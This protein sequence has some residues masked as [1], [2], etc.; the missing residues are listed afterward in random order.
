MNTPRRLVT[1]FTQWS[2]KGKS[3]VARWPDLIHVL[4]VQVG[5]DSET[6]LLHMCSVITYTHNAQL[7]AIPP[8]CWIPLILVPHLLRWETGQTKKEKNIY[9]SFHI[10]FPPLDL[11]TPI[12]IQQIIQ[13][14]AI[15][16]GSGL[17]GGHGEEGGMVRLIV[18]S[19][20]AL[21]VAQQWPI[22]SHWAKWQEFI[23]I[24]NSNKFV[25]FRCC[26]EP[27]TEPY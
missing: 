15:R 24:N 8:Y 10:T 14:C 6:N 5:V 2:F 22:I 20:A 7:E 25:F 3:G 11:S 27:Q 21:L 23:N 1:P 26:T 16:R 12:H 4:H 13:A 9:L 18:N 19:A 17:E